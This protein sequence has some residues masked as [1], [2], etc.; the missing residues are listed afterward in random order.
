[1]P[2]SALL[3]APTAD[4]PFPDLAARIQ[5]RDFTLG[6]LI[7]AAEELKRLGLTKQAAEIY[8]LWVAYNDDDKLIHFAHFN[9]A[10][11]LRELGDVAGSA[12]A[13]RAAIA[14]E[15]QFGAAHVNLGRALEDMGQAP[16]AV[17]QWRAY[18]DAT[19]AI[20]PERAQHRLM[21]LQH[22]G[23]VYENAELMQEAEAILRQAI[24]L[25]PDRTEAAQHWIALRQRQC[26]WP[27]LT[28]SEHVTR[29]QLVDAMSPMALAVQSDDPLFQLAKAYRYNKKFRRPAR[30]RAA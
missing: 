24:E 26:K 12:V 27:V 29:R 2:N 17:Q 8:K 25:R 13:L 4:L 30:G 19:A 10:V 7:H 23:R 16:R 15:P 6:D 9:H 22:L 1:M 3:K 14:A 11:A 20:T 5:R 21:A 18:L 28:P